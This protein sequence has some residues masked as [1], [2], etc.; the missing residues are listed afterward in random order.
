[1]M[2]SVALSVAPGQ[3]LAGSATWSTNPSSG[4]WNVAANWVPT[5]VPGSFSD[6]ASFAQSNNANVFIT[7]N[8]QIDGIVFNPGASAY[9]ISSAP[10]LILTI[11]GVGV[12][13]NSG[14]GQNMVTGVAGNQFGEVRFLDTA[15]A[16][17]QVTYTNSGGTQNTGL[18][19]G[20]G[21]TTEFANT[22]T[23]GAAMFVNAGGLSFLASGGVTKFLNGS[24]A[25]GATFVNAGGVGSGA[26]G[27][28]TQFRDFSTAATGTYT[29]NKGFDSNTAGGTVEFRNNSNA[30]SGTFVNNGA[31][32][33]GAIPP[34]TFFLESSSAA[35]ATITNMGG[36]DSS[37]SGGRTSF[38][39]SSTAG[40]GLIRNRAA[41][42][43]FANGGGATT[44]GGTSTAGNS[45]IINNGGTAADRVGGAIVFT[46]SS[47]AGS[48]I[49]VAEG[50]SNG[51][52]GGLINFAAQAN[53]GGLA[54]VKVFGNGKLDISQGAVPG[55]AIGSVEGTGIVFLGNRT[56]TV[57]SNNRSTHFSGVIQDF[58][59]SSSGSL[60]KAGTGTLTL[61]GASTYSGTTTVNAGRLLV[62]NTTGSG[63][64]TSII[65][66][67][68]GGSALGGDGAIAGPVTINSGAILVGGDT[69]TATGSLKLA[70]N[71]TLST[72][73]I[74]E[75]GVG[76]SS[77][78]SSLSRTGGTWTF[79]SN[80]GFNLINSGAQTGFYD[81]IITGLA[82]DPGGT[83][84]WTITTPGFSGTFAYDGAGNIDLTLTAVPSAPAPSP[85]PL[86]A[87]IATR[88]RVG[89][90]DNALIAGFILTGTQPKKVIVRAVGPSLGLAD[91]LANPTLELR[92]SSGALLAS[93]DD[94]QNQPAADRQAVIDSTIQPANDL[95][96]AVVR[97]LPA[98]GAGYTAI[99]RGVN[100]S[101]GIGV[102]EV[103]DLNISADS[104]L[105]NISTRGFVQTGDNVLIAGTIVLGPGS[106]KALV[107][108]IGPSLHIAGQLED[109]TLEVRDGNGALVRSNDNWRTGDQEA[110]IIATT[111]PPAS[112]LESAIVYDLAANGAAYTAVVRG[113][114]NTTGIA[115]VEVYALN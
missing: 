105:A 36:F 5:T 74:L 23:A 73:A 12:T 114:N 52:T 24:S 85:R 17:S 55:T 106:Q 29:N 7:A 89:T 54:Q 40:N 11:S 3:L 15:T 21:G 65:S 33:S 28:L 109:P 60:T 2:L 79:A 76:A 45:T 31:T 112:D 59:S 82:G 107:R 53:G 35:N 83:G 19:G 90:G 48:A 94:W 69:A 41:T 77:A 34:S 20:Q 46:G 111:I 113:V 49:V 10:P 8:T 93:N 110:E 104:T 26:L 96:S 63:T 64:G 75:L 16:G 91:Q 92:D 50:G 72:N 43:R 30:G 62:R 66:V 67:N 98:N 70:N 25:G 51:G 100:D 9:S 95:E 4:D 108:A 88:L 97:T 18:G 81:N 44:F 37:S 78:H 38:D 87:N 47:T 42:A 80:Q 56:L 102:V 86:L 99:V 39:N 101:T 14:I 68:A 57:G 115:V 71:L 6:T 84:S 22:S 61:S 13:N 32:V 58:S 103:Y 1:M 27:G